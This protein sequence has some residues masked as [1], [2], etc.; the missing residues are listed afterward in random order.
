M[1]RESGALANIHSNR[2]RA[3]F[4]SARSAVDSSNSWLARSAATNYV[5]MAP[6]MQDAHDALT[7]GY[8]L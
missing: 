3:Q 2:E 1:K 8:T 7:C 6:H 5:R 4:A